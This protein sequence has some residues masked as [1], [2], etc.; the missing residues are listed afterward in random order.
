MSEPETKR[1][2]R[3]VKPRNERLISFLGYDLLPA[4]WGVLADLSSS[5]IAQR[6]SRGWDPVRAITTLQYGLPGLPRG[7]AEIIAGKTPEQVLLEM[8]KDWRG[9]PLRADYVRE[10]R[11][12]LE[13][14]AARTVRPRRPRGGVAREVAEKFFSAERGADSSNEDRKSNPGDGER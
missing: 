13:R 7:I 11:E 4:Q 2:T 3:K 1:K 9:R 14:A 12:R 5:V 6:V 8:G 10:Q